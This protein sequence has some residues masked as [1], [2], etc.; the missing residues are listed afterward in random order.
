MVQHFLVVHRGVGGDDG[1]YYTC[2]VWNSYSMPLQWCP[3]KA[4]SRS[5]NAG[6]ALA[7]FKNKIWCVYV[8]TDGYLRC[9]TWPQNG[10]AWSADTAVKDSSGNNARA[11]NRTPALVTDGTTLYLIHVGLGTNQIYSC[12][13]TDGAT[14]VINTKVSNCSTE[15]GVGGVVFNGTP[16]I[17][18]PSDID[19]DNLYTSAYY[20]GSW[21][22]SSSPS[23]D[24]QPKS[25]STP[26]LQ[27]FN[28][29]LYMAHRGESNNES[30]W[31]C[32][33][34]GGGPG[35]SL[36][37]ASTDTEGQNR[38][39]DGPALVATSWGRLWC[40]HRSNGNDDSADLYGA[41]W[42]GSSWMNDVRIPDEQTFYEPALLNIDSHVY[43]ICCG[44][45][46]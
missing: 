10:T 34:K 19:T 41:L 35:G 46:P 17:V 27:V 28:G 37:L 5:T 6:P 30:I 8:T 38:S 22:S 16:Y 45:G 39:A 13:T 40:L 26:A 11:N 4:M 31:T 15:A 36:L 24:N 23:T 14:W 2:A 21:I 29:T 3:R 43:K 44:S 25:C 20:N 33:L 42:T 12:T 9:T 18:F 1:L 7:L 32:T